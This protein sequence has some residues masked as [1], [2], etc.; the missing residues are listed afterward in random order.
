MIEEIGKRIQQLRSDKGL[1]ISELA[2]RA[3]VA[4]S[5]IS[6]VE[7]GLQSN[8]SIQFL[9]KV[10]TALD[11]S[12][13]SIL[14]GDPTETDQLLDH[15]WQLLLKEAMASGI[16]K[17]QFKEFLEFQKWKKNNENPE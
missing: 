7:R 10:A 15:D 12:I 6:N 17:S 4:K 8:P 2:E 13:H 9:E 11:V 3:D 1:S 5:Y 16:S 14:N